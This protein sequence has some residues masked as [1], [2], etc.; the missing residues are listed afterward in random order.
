LPKLPKSPFDRALGDGELRR[1]I[2]VIDVINS[3]NDILAILVILAVL[4]I[5]IAGKPAVVLTC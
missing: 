4:A 3:G 1:T 2:A 5:L